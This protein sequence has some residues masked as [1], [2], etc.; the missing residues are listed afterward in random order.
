MTKEKFTASEESKPSLKKFE[1]D[2]AIDRD[3][4]DECLVRQPELLYHAS[5]QL[6]LAIDLR[7][8]I[9]IELEEAEAEVDNKIRATAEKNGDKVT[10][11]FVKKQIAGDPRIHK[12][13]QELLDAKKQVGLWEA[14][15]D[16]YKQRSYAMSSLVDLHISRVPGSS[17]SYGVSARDALIESQQMRAGEERIKRRGERR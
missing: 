10:E 5:E 6:V 13:N 4:L 17:G 14:M 3:D 7:D 12:L 16:A 9:K 8:A 15:K 11:P 1:R 2:L